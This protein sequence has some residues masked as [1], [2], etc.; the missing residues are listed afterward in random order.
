MWAEKIVDDS[1]LLLT[2][3]LRPEDGFDRSNDM[4]VAAIVPYN[5]PSGQVGVTYNPRR[6]D[7]ERWDGRNPVFI[8]GPDELPVLEATD[9]PAEQLYHILGPMVAEL[10]IDH[11][12]ISGLS[13]L[14]LRGNIAYDSPIN[15]GE[16]P[17]GRTRRILPFKLNI[18]R[19][20]LKH[21]RFTW[22]PLLGIGEGYREL[23]P[24]ADHFIHQRL[25]VSR[26]PRDTYTEKFGDGQY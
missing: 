2:D 22:H 11:K 26:K 8:V 12:M 25:L 5:A 3:F 21:H 23:M 7:L 24:Y 4:P 6:G 18:P 13:G 20:D 19:I 16:A 14:A 9:E 17:D 15:G 1:A 10:G